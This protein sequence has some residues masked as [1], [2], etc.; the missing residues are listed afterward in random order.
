M[1]QLNLQNEDFWNANYTTENLKVHLNL[2]KWRY[3]EFQLQVGKSDDAPQPPKMKISGIAILGQKVWKFT[4]TC[5]NEDVWNSNFKSESLMMHLNCKNEDFWNHNFKSE[6]L[7]MHFH[8]KK[9]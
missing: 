6:S 8:L 7:K 2:Q 3:L 4:W 9:N 1:M 5:K